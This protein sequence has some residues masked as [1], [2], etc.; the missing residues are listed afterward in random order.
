[1]KTIFFISFCVLCLVLVT[2]AKEDEFVDIL[3]EYL[4]IDVPT[5]RMCND[6]EGSF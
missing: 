4:K 2:S 3:L 1:M 6:D 5:N